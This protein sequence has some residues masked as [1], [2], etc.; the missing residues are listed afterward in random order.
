MMLN[1]QQSRK[2]RGVIDKYSLALGY[3]PAKAYID[4]LVGTAL[5]FADK[6]HLDYDSVLSVVITDLHHYYNKHVAPH[7]RGE[8]AEQVLATLQDRLNVAFGKESKL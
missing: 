8:D 5:A 2:V 3:H 6:D 4:A 7:N 1:K